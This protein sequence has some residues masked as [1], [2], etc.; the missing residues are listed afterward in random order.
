ML[1]RAGL[2]VIA[3]HAAYAFATIAGFIALPS[4]S[5]PIGDPWFAAMELLIIALAVPVVL[6]FAALARTAQEPRGW[7]LAA[8]ALAA[9][10][11]T[12]S[13]ALHAAVLALPRD[14]AL[15]AG[16]GAPLAF[17]WPSAAYAIDILAWD[18]L[19]AC[20]LLCAGVGLRGAP[21]M[22]PASAAFLLAGSV[23]LAGLIGPLTGSMPLRNL[24]ILGYALGF[25]LAVWLTLRALSQKS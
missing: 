10:A 7:F 6:F 16:E 21:A 1:R 15:V 14:H 9:A 8:L 17:V 13:A 11:L 18:V 5:E 23:A 12:T 4:S 20:A 22:R 19:F 25:P 3:L 24:G 2:A